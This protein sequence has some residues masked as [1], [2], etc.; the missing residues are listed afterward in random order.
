MLRIIHLSAVAKLISKL[1]NSFRFFVINRDRPDTKFRQGVQ[2][3]WLR[4]TVVIGVL[5][6]AQRRKY[7]VATTS[8]PVTVAAIRSFV[9]LSQSEKTI[10]AL[11][12]RWRRRLRR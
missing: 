4:D 10:L 6:E 2:F 9:I 11:A 1:I 8:Q 12:H 3:R 7:R 5:P